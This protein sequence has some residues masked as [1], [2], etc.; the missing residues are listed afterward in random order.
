MNDVVL[1]CPGQKGIVTLGFEFDVPLT[2]YETNKSLGKFILVD[3]KHVVAKGLVISTNVEEM[4]RIYYYLFL[5]LEDA[6]CVLNILHR[7]L[8]SLIAKL[9]ILWI[10]VFR[11]D[12][13][14]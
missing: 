7:D 9:W 10:G 1:S 12:R 2:S 13:V 3:Q 11:Y 14:L 8:R 4:E 5:F 6:G